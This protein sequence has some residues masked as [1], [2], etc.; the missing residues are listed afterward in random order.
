MYIVSLSGLPSSSGGNSTVFLCDYGVCSTPDGPHCDAGHCF[1]LLKLV[2]KQKWH[3][4]TWSSD[5]QME[6]HKREK[7]KWR[8]A[9]LWKTV[10]K[11][12]FLLSNHSCSGEIWFTMFPLIFHV[13][14][15]TNAIRI[16]WTMSR[17]HC[18]HTHT[19]PQYKAWDHNKLYG[20]SKESNYNIRLMLT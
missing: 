18:H 13:S 17:A 15:H 11:V 6:N 10:A 7:I 9:E 5:P 2:C 4:S 14:E 1:T 19:T 16:P 20:L 12:I 3:L 8:V